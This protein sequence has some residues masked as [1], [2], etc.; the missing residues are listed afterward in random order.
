MAVRNSVHLIGFIP[1][2]EKFVINSKVNEEELSK[3][4]YRGFLNVRRDFKNKEGQY[5]YDLMQITAFGGT[6]KYLATYAKHGDQLMIEGEVRHGQLYIHVNSA[7]IVSA[8]PSE[9][10]GTSAQASA[11][12]APKAPTGGSPLKKKLFGK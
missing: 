6:A 5:D 12:T 11:P 3:S 10:S 9:N 8:N 7:V 2:S 4:Y 1:K